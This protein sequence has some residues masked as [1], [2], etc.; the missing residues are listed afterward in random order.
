MYCK[1]CGTQISDDVDFCSVCGKRLK[2]GEAHNTLYRHELTRIKPAKEIR[3]P[4]AAAAI[5]FFMSWIFLGPVGY[6][7]LGQWNWFWLTFII[8]IFAY[9][10]TAFFAYPL[11]PIVYGIHQYQMAK[12]VNELIAAEPGRKSAGNGGAPMDKPFERPGA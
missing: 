7:Y 1:Y 9:P 12:D 4:K 10:L 3:N 8:Q 11:L 6:I 2:N 5:G